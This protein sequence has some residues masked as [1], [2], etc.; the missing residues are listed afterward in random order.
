MGAR[1][2]LE[3][4]VLIWQMPALREGIQDNF[5]SAATDALR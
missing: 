5:V 4:Q 1:S 3:A 2:I